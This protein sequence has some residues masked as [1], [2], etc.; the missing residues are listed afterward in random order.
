MYELSGQEKSHTQQ[1]VLCYCLEFVHVWL[2]YMAEVGLNVCQMCKMSD[3]WE[4][5]ILCGV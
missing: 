1:Y 5:L 4:Q 2:T 3:N